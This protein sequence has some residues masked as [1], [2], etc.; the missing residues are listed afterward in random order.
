MT[1]A[2]RR[3]GC[4][5]ALGGAGREILDEH[6]GA[7]EEA[8][9][10]RRRLRPLEIERHRLLRSIQPDEVAREPFH[11]RVVMACEVA[12]VR[13]LDLD[14]A[15]AEVGELPRRERRGH[16]LLD[17]DNGDALQ[18]SGH[19]RSA[20]RHQYDLGSPRTCSATYARIRFVEIGAT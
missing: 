3:G 17:G 10:N 2:E 1:F 11:R 12:F 5:E 4:S 13:T 9:E 18:G 7:L 6:V 16:R 20:S 19:Q 15:R 14:D 8:R